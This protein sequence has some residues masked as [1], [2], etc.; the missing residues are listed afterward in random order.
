MP[1]EKSFNVEA[2]LEKSMDAFW[3]QGYE[4]VS[5]QKLLDEMGISRASLYDTFG[6]KRQLFISALK[7]YDRENRKRQLLLISKCH[8]GKTAVRALF[9]RWIEKILGDDDL[10]G[11]F[12]TNTALELASR[13]AEIGAIVAKS[14]KDIEAFFRRHIEEGQKAGDIAPRHDSA[15]RA[16]VLLSMLL[17]LLVLSRSRPDAKLLR[18]IASG[19]SSA[20]D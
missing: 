11:C 9:D 14:Q 4:A 6:G 1:W 7:K 18:A 10:R 15:E 3:A 20:L 17:G 5:V 8:T 2:A 16:R 13:D 12:L 19:A